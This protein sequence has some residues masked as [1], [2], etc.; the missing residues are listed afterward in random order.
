MRPAPI[1]PTFCA[2]FDITKLPFHQSPAGV[3][4]GFTGSCGPSL[5]RGLLRMVLMRPGILW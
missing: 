5:V 3:R 1:Q 4:G 2:F